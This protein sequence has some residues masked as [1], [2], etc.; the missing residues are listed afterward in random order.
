MIKVPER[1]MKEVI[2]FIQE[3]C[4][5]I[6]GQWGKQRTYD[7]MVGDGIVVKGV[8][9]FVNM[10]PQYKVFTQAQENKR[11]QAEKEA[12]V[13]AKRDVRD[14]CITVEIDEE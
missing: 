1:F 4:E 2:P 7:E 3:A 6:D 5:I 8:T 14:D 11:F 9:E 12:E 10:F 13:Q